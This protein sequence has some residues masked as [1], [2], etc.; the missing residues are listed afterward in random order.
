MDAKP[1]SSVKSSCSDRSTGAIRGIDTDAVPKSAGLMDSTKFHPLNRQSG[2]VKEQADHLVP[3]QGDPSPVTGRSEG[4][5][6]LGEPGS[7]LGRAIRV[8]DAGQTARQSQESPLITSSWPLA[9]FSISAAM[10]RGKMRAND[11][12]MPIR[13]PLVCTE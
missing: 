13:K 3:R 4:R 11:N 10:R 7:P 5:G 9:G 8:W 2:R 6:G 1:S 12:S